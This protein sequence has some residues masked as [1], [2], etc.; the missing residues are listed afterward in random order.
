MSDREPYD[1][2]SWDILAYTY[3]KPT[4]LNDIEK[5]YY[6]YYRS[7]NGELLSLES[8]N[9]MQSE[10]ISKYKISLCNKELNDRVKS[11][12]LNTVEKYNI[13]LN[14]DLHKIGI[15]KTLLAKLETT[16]PI[17]TI[18]QRE[19]KPGEIITLYYLDH[20]L[21]DIPYNTL[22][23]RSNVYLNSDDLNIIKIL[24]DEKTEDLK[25]KEYNQTCIQVE[26]N[27]QQSVNKGNPK[28]L[29]IPF[30][31]A[32]LFFISVSDMPYGFYTLVRIAAF[33]LSVVFIYIWY[34][35]T[36]KFSP[37]FIPIII[38]AILWNPILPIYLDKETWVG[39]DIFAIITEIITSML[40][41]RDSKK[42]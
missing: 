5:E 18:L 7:L 2:S 12:M 35:Y 38:I 34:G 9:R 37:K 29:I 32:L 8:E 39:L 36:G 4:L 17:Q 21:P 15:C 1:R 23:P 24:L 33:I 31:L 10:M 30:V 42:E 3:S 11:S 26:P 25:S 27:S 20:K 16:T 22:S 28:T 6:Q 19:R 13:K 14:N 40:I 41:Y